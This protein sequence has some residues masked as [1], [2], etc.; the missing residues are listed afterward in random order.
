MVIYYTE[1][2]F[3]CKNPSIFHFETVI[4]YYVF[5]SLECNIFIIIYSHI[6]LE[7]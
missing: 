6:P 2:R 7:H 4:Q 1:T 3:C 5:A